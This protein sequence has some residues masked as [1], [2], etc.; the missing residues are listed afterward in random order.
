MRWPWSLDPEIAAH[1]QPGRLSRAAALPVRA[2]D[3]LI[4]KTFRL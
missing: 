4:R 1:L 2:L 3:W